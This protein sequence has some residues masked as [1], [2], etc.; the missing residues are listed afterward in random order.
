MGG[1]LHAYRFSA[2]LAD[3]LTHADSEFKSHWEKLTPAKTNVTQ[4]DVDVSFLRRSYGV[5]LAWFDVG[6]L[7]NGIEFMAG[8]GSSRPIIWID[9]NREILY[10]LMTD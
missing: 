8:H 10:F 3:L 5:N 2:P 9:T 1:R 4:A 7:S 6:K